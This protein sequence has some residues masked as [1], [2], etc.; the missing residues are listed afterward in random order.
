MEKMFNLIDVAMLLAPTKYKPGVKLNA[1]TWRFKVSLKLVDIKQDDDADECGM[2][3]LLEVT[4]IDPRD[5]LFYQT[6]CWYDLDDNYG[7]EWLDLNDNY[8]PEWLNLVRDDGTPA[9]SNEDLLMFLMGEQ[10]RPIFIKCT[11]VE[12]VARTV[13]SWE[14][15]A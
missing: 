8:V 14:P 5:D 3:S 1:Q 2:K 9:H 7:P 15:K 6:K 10:T 11:Q 13:H 4:F 12:R